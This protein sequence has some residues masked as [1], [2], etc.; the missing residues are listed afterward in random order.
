MSRAAFLS[1]FLHGA[2]VGALFLAS[3]IG[4][5]PP[6]PK[7]HSVAM[8][9]I[10]YGPGVGVKKEDDFDPTAYG[11]LLLPPYVPRPP[12]PPLVLVREGDVPPV[13][14]RPPPPKKSGDPFS[15]DYGLL[16]SNYATVKEHFRACWR[17]PSLVDHSRQD[18]LIRV[19]INIDE[20]GRIFSGA[21]KNKEKVLADDQLTRLY[22]SVMH[23]ISHPIC[24]KVYFRKTDYPRFREIEL[25]FSARFMAEP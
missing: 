10:G 9:D 19:V 8:V 17:Q 16:Y 25:E 3:S 6:L 13:V 24:R 11:S 7:P 5:E 23:A 2:F 14:L 18:K 12:Q 15:A 1:I 4:D 20:Q 22:D 21:V